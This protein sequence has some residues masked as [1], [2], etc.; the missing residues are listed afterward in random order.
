[1]LAWIIVIAVLLLLLTLSVGADVAYN[2]GQFSL[3]L[4]V[5]LLHIP[6][7]P[8]KQNGAEAKPKKKK[9]KKPKKPKDEAGKEKK[10]KQKLTL[11]DILTLAG[12]G[13]RALLRLGKHLCFDYLKLHWTAGGSDPYDTVMQYGRLNAALSALLPMAEGMLL[14]RDRDIATDLDFS[15]EKPEI[16]A[17]LELTLQIWEILCVALCAGAA[18]LVWLI[19]RKKRAPGKKNA[20]ERKGKQNG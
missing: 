11:D 8:R 1:M 10:P 12:I 2:E 13:L 20:A 19:Q 9:D 5:G 16:D 7:L 14:I 6:I 18:A 17:R 15:L 4:R 3:R